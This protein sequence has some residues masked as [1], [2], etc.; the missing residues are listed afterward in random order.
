MTK[1]VDLAKTPATV[2]DPRDLAA[3]A[4][5]VVTAQAVAGLTGEDFRAFNSKYSSGPLKG[6]VKPEE[7]RNKGFYTV[8]TLKRSEALAQGFPAEVVPAF[9]KVKVAVTVTIVA[10]D[11]DDA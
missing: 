9:G 11:P 8:L 2:T 10:P 3:M 7:L 6:E 4:T 5:Q 1:T